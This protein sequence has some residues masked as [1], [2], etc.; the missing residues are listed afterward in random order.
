MKIIPIILIS[1]LIGS[2][3]FGYILYYLKYK[4][5]IRTKGS[6]NPGGTNVFRE[7]GAF[8]GILTTLLDIAKSFIPVLLAK[9]YFG[10]SEIIF[11]VW[12]SIVIG[13]MFSIFLGF[14]GGKGVA[15]TFGGVLGIDY[16][17]FIIL[18]IVYLTIIILTRI[19]SIGSLS[20]GILLIIAYYYFYGSKNIVFVVIIV[21]FVFLR[22]KENIKRIIAGKE[23][24]VVKK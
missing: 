17:I 13:H 22:H 2:I 12:L 9:Q 19:S 4:E 3:P 1:Y 6:G 23:K 16:R 14:K 20:S 8:L 10:F 5:D 11:I 21:A 24:K 18:L 7:G 15:A